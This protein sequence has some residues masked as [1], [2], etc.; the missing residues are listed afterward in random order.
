MTY[1][2]VTQFQTIDN[3]RRVL[4]AASEEARRPT[5][6]RFRPELGSLAAP[7]PAPAADHRVAL[8]RAVK[9][10]GWHRSS[11]SCRC[12]PARLRRSRTRRR[13]GR[14]PPG[15]SRPPPR[16]PAS[17]SPS[18][19]RTRVR[20]RASSGGSLAASTRRSSARSRRL[21]SA[22]TS[23]SCSGSSARANTSLV[24]ALTKGDTSSKAVKSVDAEDP[25]VLSRG[26]RRVTRSG[27]SLT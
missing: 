24:F 6:R 21:T 20:A 3:R 18:R 23:S 26:W 17:S 5:R 19:F 9:A 14:S 15:R 16:G 27:Q 22:R 12:S 25:L 10:G 4:L 1:P 8:Q 2:Q 11:R 7:S 13:L